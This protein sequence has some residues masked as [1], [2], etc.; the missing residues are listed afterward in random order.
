MKKFFI[1][2]DERA[3]SCK[4]VRDF[5][6]FA[7]SFFYLALILKSSAH[8]TL[9]AS[10]LRDLENPNLSVNSRAEMR[11]EAA[12]AF[13]NKGGY[14]EARKLL[15]TY[16]WRIGEHPK[17]TDLDQ[18]ASAEVLLRAGVLTGIIG[19]KNQIEDAQEKAKDLLSES[20]AIFES[21]R[22]QKKVAETQ[23]ELALCYWR[24]GE[25]SEA[26]DLLKEALS[27][28][29]IDSDLKAK[30]II[31]L[32]IVER[33]ASHHEKAF[34][35]LTKHGPLFD[36]IHN[37]TLKGSYH[38]TLGNALEDLSVLKK[39]RDYVDRALIEY[40]ASSYHFEQA[41]HR[42]YLASVEN[43]LGMLY[44]RINRCDEA[45]VHLDRARRVFQ[46]LKDVG[47]MAQVDETRACVFLQQGRVIDAER[48]ARLAVQNQEKTGRHALM[49]EALV[50]H[51][52]ALARLERYGAALLA[53]RR[54]IDLSEHAGN[55]TRAA[56]AALAAFQEI[57]KRLVVSE[58]GQAVS[59]KGWG[60]DKRAI[61][62]DLI[63]L[64]LEQSNGSVTKAARNLG[65]S[66]PSLNY[67]LRTRYK[68]LLK[69]R[70]PIQRRPRK[71]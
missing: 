12:K 50:T 7:R 49:A 39:R 41:E 9:R 48:V 20:H 42:C 26:R 3:F 34:R 28:L 55:T 53:F 35:I 46:S 15:A 27:R 45:H 66:Y 61:E 31:R 10:L 33:G 23:T 29:T 71:A 44:F 52:K 68:D 70:T 36:R 4:S 18:N 43:N 32:A 19:G 17:L 56:G 13:E 54:A 65:I 58:Q 38:D 2:L 57:G 63:K 11:C 47:S 8:M 16:W 37:H 67:M 6:R 14:E 69:Y 62:H 5:V 30:A 22:N 59:G 1:T 40:A 60:H 24:T 25:I 21:Q 51:G 64:A